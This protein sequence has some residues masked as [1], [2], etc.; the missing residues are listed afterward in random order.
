MGK[1]L[2]AIEDLSQKLAVMN[3]QITVLG[4]KVSRLNREGK[5]FLDT[6]SEGGNN[7]QDRL[8]EM[9]SSFNK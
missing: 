6:D 5:E 7:L 9:N 4:T 8:N 3:S 1:H 2:F